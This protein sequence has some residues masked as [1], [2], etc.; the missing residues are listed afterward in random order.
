MAEF[1]FDGHDALHGIWGGNPFVV[2]PGY[3]QN[4]NNRFFREDRNTTR[5]SI[6]NVTLTFESDAQKTFFQAANGQG[7]TF[8]NTY[9]SYLS[10]KLVC[11]LGGRLYTI[12]IQGRIGIVKQ[13]FDGNSR[14]FMH[15]WF[16]QGFN[17]LIVQDG[18]SPPIMWDGTNAATRSNLVKNQVPIGS[19]MAFIHGRFVVASADGKNSI[20]VGDIAYGNTVTTPDDI[21]NFTER[22]YWAEGGN[23]DTPV[24][25]GNIMGL[26]GMPFLDTGTGQNELV[27]GC[28]GGFASLDL[29]APRDQWIN[30]QVQKV[31]LIG[32]GLVSSHGFCGLN[33]DMFYRAQ[34]GISTYRNARIEY[35]QSWNQK[36]L[37]REVNYWLKPDR[38][39]LLEFIPQVSFQNMV[40]TGCSPLVAPP[41]N[42]AL[43]YHRYCR[44]M[45]VFDADSMS[46][47]SGTGTPVWHGMWSGI[48]PWAFAQGIIQNQQRCFA[49]SYDRDG[50][51]RLYEI[52]IQ[53]GDDTFETQPRRVSSFYLTGELGTVE[54]RT[55]AFAPKKLN[56]GVIE[57]SE[58]LG[59]TH[60]TIEYRPDGSPCWIPI[61]DGDPGCDCP[62]R[63]DPCNLNAAP[64]WGRAYFEQVQPNECVPGSDQPGWLFHHCQVKVGMVGPMTI[65]RLN[66][67]MDPQTD[68]QIAQCITATCDPIDCCPSSDDYAYHIAPVG[69]NMNVPVVPPDPQTVF[70]ATRIY[71]AV[72][73]N[74]T[75]I[76]FT[77]TGQATSLI[78]QADAD[79][80]AQQAA[81]DNAQSQL[82][83]PSCVPLV[84]ADNMVV[85]GDTIDYSAFFVSG[86]QEGKQG[87][88]WRILNVLTGGLVASGIVNDSGTLQTFQLYP[89]AAYGGGTFDPLTNI[90]TDSGSGSAR[91]MLQIGCLD[92][93]TAIW[94]PLGGYGI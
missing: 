40:F 31:A 55:N 36:P 88:P 66:I 42:P 83:C 70:T 9:P 63:E 76:S 82:I 15:A 86:A 25:L 29:S 22:Q 59:E 39:D 19:V 30:N 44:G 33:G 32:S 58:L 6:Q 85:E 90:Y 50:V 77:G 7:A 11:S 80:K 37:S 71:T 38:R 78:S 26:Y 2:P 94:P 68:S 13:L 17:W 12:E 57:Y 89:P 35:A 91:V 46:R 18:I 34:D 49:F 67:R 4:A 61:T 41:N 24:F 1:I 28:T 21:L 10:P 20:F 45:V 23:F 69:T 65:N 54:A 51:N 73:P 3:A 93:G 79:Q 43:G 8:Y 5:P 87:R 52:T 75:A 62:T 47:A 72:C 92:G 84:L 48:R 53:Q 56:G 14:Q 60:F 81:Y 64:Q 27:I 16:A 74:D